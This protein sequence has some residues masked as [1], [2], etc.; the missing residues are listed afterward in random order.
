ALA[1]WVSA[2]DPLTTAFTVLRLVVL[3]LAWYLLGV[4]TIGV[5]ARLAR[6]AR[7]VALADL[8]TVAPVRRLLSAAL[9]VGLAT[10]AVTSLPQ[11]PAAPP[12]TVVAEAAPSAEEGHG[13]VADPGHDVAVPEGGPPDVAV[14]E[15]GSPDVAVPE[16]GL[17]VDGPGH[18]ALGEASSPAADDAAGG[19]ARP[20]GPELAGMADLLAGLGSVAGPEAGDAEGA[21]AAGEPVPSSSPAPPPSAPAGASDDGPGPAAWR[22]EAGDHLWSI[23]AAVLAEARGVEVADAEVAAYWRALIEANRD[24][25]PD[26]ANPDLIRPGLVL[27]LPDP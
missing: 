19:T 23:A 4:T 22:V 2:E 5:V 6:A 3:A 8:L 9:G 11:A 10:A 20:A 21:P 18:L 13:T 15:G 12:P 17:P 24:A 25:L 1:A 14:P 26:P 7:V 27:E 16:G